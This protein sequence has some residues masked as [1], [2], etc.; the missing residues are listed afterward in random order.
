[1]YLASTIGNGPQV[2]EKESFS[3][4]MFN[5]SI[6]CFSII[7]LPSIAP[8]VN[9]VLLLQD[10]KMTVVFKELLVPGAITGRCGRLRKSNAFVHLFAKLVVFSFAKPNKEK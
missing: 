3:L 8:R 9:D 7:L 4:S 10:T 6:C 5:L 1:M 2:N